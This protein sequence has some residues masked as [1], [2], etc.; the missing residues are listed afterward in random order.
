[1]T[2][3]PNQKAHLEE[4][5]DLF[6]GHTGTR[7]VAQYFAD[8]G[9]KGDLYERVCADLGLEPRRPTTSRGFDLYADFRDRYD[10][11]VRVQ[12]SSLAFEDCAWIFVDDNRQGIK[13]PSAHLTVEMAKTVR[14]A[15]DAFIKEH[16]K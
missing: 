3:Y 12:K 4:D 16:D 5:L 11:R 10:S 2:L 9:Y 6:E 15:L 8:Y 1:M 7:D 14:D 13:E